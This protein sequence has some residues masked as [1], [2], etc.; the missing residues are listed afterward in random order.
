MLRR[1]VTLTFVLLPAVLL[2]TLLPSAA[3]SGVAPL[4][5][6]APD[7]PSIQDWSIAPIHLAD[8]GSTAQSLPSSLAVVSTTVPTP[9]N[10]SADGPLPSEPCVLE[11]APTLPPPERPKPPGT[12]FVA[13]S[14]DLSHLKGDRLPEGVR[15]AALPA[16][17]D[18]RGQ[19]I[20]TRVQ[21]QGACGACYAFGF[22]AN[23]EAKLQIDGAGT[24]DFSENMVK[25]CNWEELNNFQDPP[26]SPW[27]GC[28]GGNQFMLANLFSAKGAVLE[29]CDP[30]VPRDD[31]P[32]KTTCP[33]Q[34]TVLDWR[35][36][37]GD[38]LPD[39]DVLK[40]YI[41]AYGPATVSMYAGDGD[42]WEREFGRYDGSYTL[43][44][45]GTEPSNHCVTIVGWDDNL[46]HAGGRGGW[47]VKN[48][49]GTDWGGT[50]GYGHERGYFTIAYGSASIGA[51]ATFV[52]EWQDYDPSGGLMYYDDAGWNDAVGAGSRT[53]WG[54]AKFVPSKN[55]YVTR[56]EFWTTDETTDVDVY[57]YDSFDGSSLGDLLW[58]QMDVSY[59]E[60]GYHSVPVNPPVPVT[61]GDDV[62]AV[63]KFTNA[64]S[65]YPVP[66]DGRASCARQRS[67]VSITGVDGSWID[68]CAHQLESDVGIRLRTSDRPEDTPTPTNTRTVTPTASPTQTT[69]PT[70]TPT[71]VRRIYLPVVLRNFRPGPG[72]THTPADTPTATPTQP[73]MLTPTNTAT[74]TP[75]GAPTRTS[76]P[77][78]IPTITPTP[79]TGINVYFDDFSDPNSGWPEDDDPDWSVGYL[80]EEYRFLMKSRNMSLRVTA[81]QLRCVDCTVEVD[82]RYATANYGF[83]GLIFGVTDAWDS[84][85]FLVD[86]RGYFAIQV[87]INNQWYV[88]VDWAA[89][90]H[91]NRGQSSN[92][93][94]IVRSGD[95]IKAYINGQFVATVRNDS[96]MGLLRT[97][98]IVG[99]GD[100]ADVDVRFDNFRATASGGPDDFGYVYDSRAPFSW[101]DTSGGAVVPGGDDFC[102][103]PY[104]IGFTF[105]FY[106]KDY[107]TFSVSTNGFLLLGDNC[108]GGWTYT[109]AAIPNSAFP[110]G[111]VAPFWDDL[112]PISG[113]VLRYETFG[114]APNRY[115]VVEWNAVGLYLDFN[116][117]VTFQAI[118]YEG[119]NDIKFQYLTMAHNEYGDGSSASVGIEDDRGRIGLGY[120]YD[121]PSI[122]DGHA[123]YFLYPR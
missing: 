109:N 97:G 86:E 69:R 38:L 75:T 119:T 61:A 73:G 16:S 53:L 67:Y 15:A 50:C 9:A 91:I 54:L 118:L 120:S 103:G 112:K 72:P 94:C 20:I 2:I 52:Y 35:L 37:N 29:S 110:N 111:I 70:Q 104:P 68:L 31:V 24:F 59:P 19:G 101:L 90:P 78:E 26:G 18:W 14:M 107:T 63:V 93:L 22:L 56:A 44:H 51:F 66:S 65:E 6:S 76:T 39:P 57:I 95:Q 122:R 21:D 77:T 114:S 32:C 28:E 46:S 84:Y 81:P 49:W 47:I 88:L 12:G 115:L 17:F 43:Y 116:H 74:P 58:S 79:P 83:Y 41:Q 64:S 89:S 62:A 30:Y 7:F 99:A 10:I 102:R 87:R 27:G 106:G 82:A 85:A 8:L 4:Q 34:K 100:T 117:P 108:Q 55:E 121:R 23:F 80:G 1:L 48:S 123:V 36:I 105:N 33:Y 98:L 13:P 11:S 25:E 5:P 3:S 60:A 92:H 96:L 113:A 40:G 71:G 45:P 42:A